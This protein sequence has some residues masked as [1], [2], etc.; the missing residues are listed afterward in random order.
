MYFDTSLFLIKQLELNNS[1]VALSV[2]DTEQDK[3]LNES[4]AQGAWIFKGKIRSF[5]CT[6][7]MGKPESLIKFVEDRKGNDFRYSLDCEKTNQELN[8]KA[9]INME[10]GLKKTI[11]WYINNSSYWKESD[12]FNYYY[13]E[14]KYTT[15]H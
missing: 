1:C 2:W 15:D 3:I 14:R 7:P 6:I 12:V 10:E 9:N 5:D 4:S 11:E 8:W 13:L